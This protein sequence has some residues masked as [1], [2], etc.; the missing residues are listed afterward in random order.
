MKLRDIYLGSVA[1]VKQ[2]SI[3]Q[4]RYTGEPGEDRPR[5]PLPDGVR[6]RAQFRQIG[7]VPGYTVW[8]VD[9]GVL[10][11]EVDIDFTNGGNPEVYGYVPSGELWVEDYKGSRRAKDITCTLLHE[12]VEVTLMQQGQTYEDAH[13]AATAVEDQYRTRTWDV[14]EGG[15]APLVVQLYQRWVGEQTTGAR[16]AK[17]RRGHA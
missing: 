16:V 14:N 11:D 9:G 2:A 17:S 3:S 1:R 13:E 8:L 7:Q 4:C 6:A 5:C 10:R 15:I 12:L